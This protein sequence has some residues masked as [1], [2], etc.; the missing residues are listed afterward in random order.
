MMINP[1]KSYFKTGVNS[2]GK[3]SKKIH[4]QVFSYLALSYD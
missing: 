1:S 3:W 4:V 2:D